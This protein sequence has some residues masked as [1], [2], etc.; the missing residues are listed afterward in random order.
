VTDKA[1]IVAAL[2]ASF[3]HVQAAARGMTEP[4]S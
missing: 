3:R 1:T 2:E 4:T